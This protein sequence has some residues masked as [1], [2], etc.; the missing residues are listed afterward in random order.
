MLRSMFYCA[1]IVVDKTMKRKVSHYIK[2]NWYD[3]LIPYYFVV[4]CTDPSG[5][6]ILSDINIKFTNIFNSI[7]N[8]LKISANKVHNRFTINIDAI[9]IDDN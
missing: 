1:K 9:L 6:N 7:K 5:K 3:I 8:D 4:V 2:E